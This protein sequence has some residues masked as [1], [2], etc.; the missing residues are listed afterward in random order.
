MIPLAAVL[1]VN[2][3]TPSM[4]RLIPQE[5]MPDP[6]V[7]TD[8]RRVTTKAQWNRE[9]K[10]ELKRLFQEYMY[11]YVPAPAKIHAK[12]EREDSQALG[13]KAT[14]RE[15]TINLGPKGTRPIHLLLVIP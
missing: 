8:G 14:L 15:V 6:L 7:M 13:G 5:A 11:G 2:Q 3:G 1:L 12:V 9:R 4:A 10:P